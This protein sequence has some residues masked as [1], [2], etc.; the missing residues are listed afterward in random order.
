MILGLIERLISCARQLGVT[1]FY[2]I[3]V[4]GLSTACCSKHNSE[5]NARYQ[6]A[7]GVPIE[8]ESLRLCN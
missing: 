3:L 8:N 5:S 2:A 6:F 7:S 1:Q 4:R